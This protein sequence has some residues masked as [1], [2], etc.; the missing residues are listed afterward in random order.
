MLSIRILPRQQLAA[1]EA[2]AMLTLLRCYFDEVSADAFHRDLAEK[3]WVILLQHPAAGL[4]GFSTQ[5][6]I[7]LRCNGR[8]ARFLFSGDTIVHHRHWNQPGLAGAFGHLMARLLADF[9][10]D[11]LYWFLISKG[12]RTYRFLPVFF[13]DFHPDPLRLRPMGERLKVPLDAIAAHKFGA[14]Y[15]PESGIIRFPTP[16]DRLK[17]EWQTTPR[18]PDADPYTR[19]FFSA[20]PGWHD[21]EELA[22]I[23]PIRP[24]N[25]NALNRRVTRA[26]QVRWS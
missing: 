14:C 4:V 25:F 22:C 26:T 17:P 19:F 15:H 6:L 23:T 8:S 13:N 10:G 24:D 7:S 18:G 21:G 2:A 9:P 16:K 11:D 12:P 3:E 5:Q 1:A 20:N